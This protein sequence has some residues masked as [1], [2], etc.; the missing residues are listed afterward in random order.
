MHHPHRVV[1]VAVADLEGHGR[2][3]HRDPGRPG[4]GH[5]VVVPVERRVEG[6]AAL[7]HVRR[8]EPDADAVEAPRDDRLGQVERVAAHQGIGHERPEGLDLVQHARAPQSVEGVGVVGLAVAVGVD[9]ERVA[10]DVVVLPRLR[11]EH[12]VEEAA[13]VHQAVLPDLLGRAAGLQFGDAR[14]RQVEPVRAR[15]DLDAA[16]VGVLEEVV[17]RP[18]VFHGVDRA[19]DQ[20][21]G[22]ELPEPADLLGRDPVGA[23]PEVDPRHPL[24]RLPAKIPPAPQVPGARVARRDGRQGAVPQVQRGLRVDRAAHDHVVHDRRGGLEAV[25]Q[26]RVPQSARVGGERPHRVP[27]GRLVAGV[28][29]FGRRTRSHLEAQRR[30]ARGEQRVAG[31]RLEQRRLGRLHDTGRRQQACQR[32][33]RG[34]E[35][36]DSHEISPLFSP[37]PGIAVLMRVIIRDTGFDRQWAALAPPPGGAIW[38]PAPGCPI[39]V[40]DDMPVPRS[41][42]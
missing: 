21:V 6:R 25:D 3:D 15:P 17:G 13:V 32:A 20:D 40:G 24:D 34:Q 37:S 1:T 41:L 7:D 31:R 39:I 33:G 22:V 38:T 23:Q 26:G 5:P 36:L 11:E 42:P 29:A 16:A 14:L 27:S 9:R 28:P 10:V 4:E 12:V 35:P 8:V 2:L 19:E 30:G 18:H